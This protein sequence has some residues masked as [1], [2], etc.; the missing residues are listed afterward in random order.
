MRRLP[1]CAIALLLSSGTSL[2]GFAEQAADDRVKTS[3]DAGWIRLFDGKSLDG[4]YTYLQKHKKNEDPAKVF[5]VHDGVIHVYKDQAD[6]GD[7]PVGYLASDSEYAYCHLRLEYKWGNK[8]FPPRAQQRRD[9]G[10]LYHV[11]GADM[12]WPRCIECQIQ[13]NDTGDCFTVRGT[14]VATSVEIVNVETPSGPKELPR[15]KP[16]AD[17]GVRKTVGDGQIARI[18]KSSTHERDGWNKVEAIVRGSDGTVHIVNGHLVFEATDLRQLGRGNKSWE[19]LTHGR[20]ALQAEYAEVFYRNIEIRLIP[21][22][23][24]YPTNKGIQ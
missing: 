14:Q 11:V 23:P 2:C 19:P 15:Y 13:E 9:A 17:D 21:E 5:Q 7:V 6:G 4:W 10:L 8:K 18:V 16:E 22:G 20:I 24:L 12:V 1:A 3:T